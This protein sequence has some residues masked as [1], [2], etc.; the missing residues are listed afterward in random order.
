MMKNLTL[1]ILLSG[2]LSGPA[3]AQPTTG[4]VVQGQFRPGWQTAT[5]THMTALHLRLAPDWKTYW[6]APG[7][8]GIP[9]QFNWAGSENVASVRFF[10]PAPDV[11]RT[12]GMQTVGYH[13]ELVL[14]FEVT[15]VDPSRPVRLRASVDLGVCKDICVPA[16]LTLDS[17]LAAPG[18]A[19]ATITA[20][21]DAQPMTARQAGL[22]SITCAL[23]PIADGLRITAKMDLPAIGGQEVVVFEAGSTDIWVSQSQVQRDGRQLQASADMVGPS[24]QPFSLDRGAVTVTV[25]GNQGRAVELRGCPAG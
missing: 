10:W 7:D 24:G 18:R 22:G 6:R 1:G 2:L 15:A 19:D 16:T 4:D 23:T 11:F 3:L 21:L 12:N 17:L 14:P 20:A 9:P 8:A 5:G 13:D 25:I